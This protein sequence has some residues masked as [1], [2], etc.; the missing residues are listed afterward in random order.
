MEEHVKETWLEDLNAPASQDLNNQHHPNYWTKNPSSLLTTSTITSFHLGTGA[1]IYSSIQPVLESTTTELVLVTC[2]WARSASLE[3]LNSTLLALSQKA[4]SDTQN[5]ARKI[6]VRIYFSSLSLFQKLFHTWSPKGQSYPP[7]AW[8][9]RLGLPAPEHLQ[10]LDLKIKSIFFLPF[11]VM[12]PK[13]IIV[14]RRTVFL[15][16]CNVSWE[17]WFEGC[18]G[19]QGDVV[20]RFLEFWSQFWLDDED[21]ANCLTGV[22]PATQNGVSQP[23]IERPPVHVNTSS[24]QDSALPL[25]KSLTLSQ[26]PTVFLPSSHHINPNF[27]P[28]WQENAQPPPTPLNTFLL[29]AI[30]CATS[31]IY[32]QTP[33]LTSPPVLEALLAALRRGVDVTIVTSER[34]MVLEQLVTAGTT[35][36]RCV[37]QLVR[38]W[39]RVIDEGM[40]QCDL[41]RE[42]LMEEG[43]GDAAGMLK[44]NFYEPTEANKGR[45]DGRIRSTYDEPTMEEPVQSHLKLTV[46]DQELVVLGSG[47]LDRAS[48]YTSQELG[49]AFSSKELAAEIKNHLEKALWGRTKPLFDGNKHGRG[50]MEAHTHA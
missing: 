37:R 20:T 43:R 35:T 2:F 32:I 45:L 21:K 13:F 4:L 25:N 3:I 31:E 5:P 15:P 26:V 14:D 22:E 24:P 28:P 34:L 40:R 18:V 48:W 41:G 7:S 47:N 8:Q 11:S 9:P 36:G 16:S 29:R 39:R 17:D 30:A 49:V 46:V 42:R 12:H 23:D 33:N 38:R 44:V 27:R 6:R 10:G 50:E 1:S 19:L